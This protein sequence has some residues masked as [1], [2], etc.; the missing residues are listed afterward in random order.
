M[1]TT[2]LFVSNAHQH[3]ANFQDTTSSL[4]RGVSGVLLC[5]AFFIGL[6]ILTLGSIA[7][8]HW[9]RPEDNGFAFPRTTSSSYYGL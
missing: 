9:L 1:A 2:V 5:W 3:A 7:L 6:G 4:R 8:D